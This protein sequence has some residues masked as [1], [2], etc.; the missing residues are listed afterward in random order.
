MT[1]YR[2]KFFRI[3]HLK[4]TQKKPYFPRIGRLKRQPYKKSI[5]EA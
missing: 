5:Q 1:R 3:V 2:T 4:E